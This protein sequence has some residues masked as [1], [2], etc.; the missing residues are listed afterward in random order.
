MWWTAVGDFPFL[1]L[2]KLFKFSFEDSVFCL[3]CIHKLALFDS[4]V[5]QFIHKVFKI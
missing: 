5:L 4:D 3:E 2:Y 1:S